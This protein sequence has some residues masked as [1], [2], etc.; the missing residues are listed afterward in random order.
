MR[1]IQIEKA[2]E[3]AHYAQK[4]NAFYRLHLGE[5]PIKDFQTLPFIDGDTLRDHAQDMLCQSLSEVSRIRTFSTSGSTGSQKRIFF[6]RQ[7]QERTTAFF[8]RGMA[9][10]T[11]PE[12]TVAILMSDDK[13]GSIATLLSQGLRRHHRHAL[14][15]GRPKDLEETLAALVQVDCLVGMPAD[16][17][18]L[19]QKA[20]TLKIP[21][22]LL[23]ADYISPALVRR[24]EET[25]KAKVYTHYGLTETCYG[26]AVQCPK[27]H[28][29]HLRDEDFYLEIIDPLT[30]EV[31]PPGEKGEIVISSL[32]PS[33]LP[34][35][36]YRTGD[37]GCLSQV[38]CP[39]GQ[40][41]WT[42]KEVYGRL[43]NLKSPINI[44]LL[45]DLL[46]AEKEVFAYEAY[47]HEYFLSLTIDGWADPNKLQAYL[48]YP[49]KITF[50]SCPPWENP[51]KRRLR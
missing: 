23:S 3:I 43:D 14:I 1:K 22:L 40:A 42:L 20:P 26:L 50:A 24:I 19:C 17:Y 39:C 34:L 27:R 10:L 12:S 48:D 2:L 51:G 32:H 36:R 21:Q 18:Y 8:G 25:W 28:G 37:C 11:P 45:D 49:L 16:V 7:D 31:L 33:P 6:G 13:P 29:M 44:H 30:K 5:S 4:N 41:G 15:Y 46:Y 38:P 35:I 9:P 47:F